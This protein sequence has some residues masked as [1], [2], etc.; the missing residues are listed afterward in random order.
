MVKVW[1]MFDN[2]TFERV[3]SSD[4]ASIVRDAYR[5]LTEDSYGM[6][7][8]RDSQDATMQGLYFHGDGKEPDMAK[9][10]AW[11]SRV[12]AEIEFDRLMAA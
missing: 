12:M 11:A 9:I 10:D 2:H 5:L 1:F 4:H 6:L 8:V 7:V 3:D